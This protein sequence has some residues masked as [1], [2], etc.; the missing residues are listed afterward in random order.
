MSTEFED[1]YHLPLGYQIERNGL[2]LTL[3]EEG[4]R[5]EVQHSMMRRCKGWD[6][7][8]PWIYLV[9]IG[10]QHHDIIPMPEM[11]QATVPVGWQYPQWL[12]EVYSH[13][14][15]P[16]LFGELT[17]NTEQEAKIA[18]NPFGQAVYK[19]IMTITQAYPQIRIIEK[20]VMPNHIHI[21]MRIKEPLPEKE[22]LGIVLKNFKSWV[23]RT[24]KLTCLGLPVE[25]LMDL[26]YQQVGGSRGVVRGAQVGNVLGA[27]SGNVSGS[28]SQ[29]EITKRGHGSKNPK[30]GLVFESGYNDRILFR[31]GQLRNMIDYCRD[32]PRRLWNVVHNSRYFRT[33]S[34]IRLTMPVLAT[35]GTKGRGRWNGPLEGLIAPVEYTPCGSNNTTIVATG[36]V[37]ASGMLVVTQFTQTVSFNAIGNRD[38][39]TVPEL[40]QIQCSR[41]M[42]EVEIEKLKADVLEACKHGVVPISPCIS[43]GEKAVARAVMEAG[44]NLIAL[45]PQGIPE[46]TTYKPYKQYFDAC[47]NGQLL[48]LSPWKFEVG[49][50]HV[51]LWQCLFLNDIAMQLMVGL[52]KMV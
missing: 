37:V 25:T 28:Q 18:L 16:H 30:I 15:K 33:V 51:A 12:K 3:T 24:Y 23:N 41:S 9:T 4:W 43:P 36:T 29:T 48:L 11:P 22:P 1:I 49:V 13:S 44:Y 19:Q 50:N 32:N 27:L 6:Y 31:K 20:I 45:F 26:S 42:S 40:I 46:D 10:S 21:V 2:V 7:C 52:T 47:A 34:G 5:A 38:L 17:G 39:L 8:K 35:G 14:G